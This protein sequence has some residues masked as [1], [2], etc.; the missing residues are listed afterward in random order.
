MCFARFVKPSS[1]RFPEP[2]LAKWSWADPP[3]TCKS[4][5]EVAR[6]DVR[7][8]A[9]LPGAVDADIPSGGPGPR[10]MAPGVGTGWPE[11]SA[12]PPPPR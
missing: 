12:D 6:P 11:P 10:S 3:V 9:T 4:G 1:V 7:E 2:A 5:Q 8:C